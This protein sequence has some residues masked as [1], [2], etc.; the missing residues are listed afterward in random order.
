MQRNHTRTRRKHKHIM[1]SFFS[2]LF[3]VSF[4]LTFSQ[5]VN[6]IWGD[7]TGEFGR[8][9]KMTFH[10]N[11]LYFGVQFENKIIKLDL[12][13]PTSPIATNVIENLDL[14]SN[15]IAIRG[16]YL[17]FSSVYGNTISKIDL[18]QTNPQIEIVV[19]GLTRPN[20]LAFYNNNLYVT[21]GPSHFNFSG[22]ISKINIDNPNPIVVD[23]LTGLM[24]PE[25]IIIQNDHLFCAQYNDSTSGDGGKVFKLDLSDPS[26][27][28][29]ELISELTNV[30]AIT[31]VNND[32]FIGTY[33]SDNFTPSLIKI[34][35]DIPN[36]DI[37]TIINS[38]IEVT[39]LANNGNYLYI[40]DSS[41]SDVLS[42]ELDTI[43]GQN[44]NKFSNK[45]VVFP[46][47]SQDI[48]FFSNL[49]QKNNDYTI[50]DSVGRVITKGKLNSNKL[51]INTLKTGIY[52]IKF[53][54]EVP[55][56]FI[57]E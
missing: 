2:L 36:P 33:L 34:D 53:N 12:T 35:L 3:F 32:L 4:S 24:R 25:R 57:K 50:T 8:P 26:P 29:I 38:G 27:I 37:T 23:V 40:A 7:G 30:T 41:N 11:K 47:P 44:D 46:N 55:L 6:V 42:L 9:L 31:I 56:K 20:S 15:A 10:E 48:L 39:D 22:K 49:P 18:T 43:L 5:N 28:P 13:N 17:Y 54:N 52:L 1:R 14:D 16:D 19:S 21:H 51:D 45:V